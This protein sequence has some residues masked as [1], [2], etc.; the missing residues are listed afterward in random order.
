[1][2][3][4]REFDVA[5]MSLSTYAATLNALDD[6]EEP[7]FVALPVYTSRQFRHGGM[8]INAAAGVEKP[9]DLAGGRIGMPE[10]QL[11]ASNPSR[12][13]A[14]TAYADA[15]TAMASSLS[16]TSRSAATPAGTEPPVPSSLRTT[17]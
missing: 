11:T 1:M 4:H 16:G 6:G 8:F 10:V 14:R 3:R 5:E 17:M 12:R 15:D 7:P 9:A 13:G 2:L